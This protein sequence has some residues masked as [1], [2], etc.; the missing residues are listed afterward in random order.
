MPKLIVIKNLVA[1]KAFELSNLCTATDADAS[2]LNKPDP[3]DPYTLSP[4]QLTAA[5]N[6][7]RDMVASPESHAMHRKDFLQVAFVDIKHLLEAAV[8]SLEKGASHLKVYNAIDERGNH[9]FFMAPI[10][11]HGRARDDDN[12]MAAMCCCRIPPCPETLTDRY[13]EP[14]ERPGQMQAVDY[15]QE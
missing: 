1:D 3:Q 7:F 14:R 9:F 15:R 10:D 12:T 6:R 8:L 5:V 11:A 4:E 2:C 13:F